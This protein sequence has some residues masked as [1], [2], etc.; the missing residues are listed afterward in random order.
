V[1]PG[2][3]AETAPLSSAIATVPAEKEFPEFTVVAVKAEYV[4]DAAMLPTAPNT[5]SVARSFR[6]LFTAV[7]FRVEARR[8][9][10]ERSNAVSARCQGGV[11]PDRGNP[12]WVIS[13]R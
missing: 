11:S 8:R 13:S 9:A 3:I 2:N 1:S 10:S 4:P 6:F 5:N 12:R 7:P